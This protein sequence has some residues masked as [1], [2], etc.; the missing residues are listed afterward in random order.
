MLHNDALVVET[1]A[2]HVQPDLSGRG[3][4]CEL[5]GIGTLR[6][7]AR[8]DALNPAIKDHLKAPCGEGRSLCQLGVAR[9]SI[10]PF[11]RDIAVPNSES[12]AFS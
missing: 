10:H 11:R 8:Q 3:E 1:Y 2:E 12:R 9:V 4:S 7:S 6:R 5:P